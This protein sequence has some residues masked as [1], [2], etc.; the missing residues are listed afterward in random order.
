MTNLPGEIELIIDYEGYLVAQESRMPCLWIPSLLGN[1]HRRELLIA[2]A[3]LCK[4]HQ[5]ETFLKVF[6]PHCSLPDT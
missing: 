3:R 6:F 4:S 5:M 1:N 2:W